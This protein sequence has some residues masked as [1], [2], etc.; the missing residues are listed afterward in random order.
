MSLSDKSCVPCKVG[1]PKLSLSEAK[2]LLK[3]LKP[4]WKIEE[5]K[6]VLVLVNELV[7]EN[8]A[9]AIVFINNLA[10]VCE[11]QGHHANFYLHDW[12]KLKLELYTHKINGLHENDFILASKI[13][14]L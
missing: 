10:L 7:F 9:K 5:K 1:A 11:E 6:D 14:S 12:N 2:E 4:G 8:F 13:D 3:Q